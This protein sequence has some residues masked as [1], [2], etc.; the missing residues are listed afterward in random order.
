LIRAQ[1]LI[2]NPHLSFSVRDLD[3]AQYWKTFD[4]YVIPLLAK[5]MDLTR[6]EEM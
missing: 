4:P 1:P 6:W 3:T 5:P 2:I